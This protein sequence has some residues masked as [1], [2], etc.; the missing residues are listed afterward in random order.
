MSTW[1]KLRTRSDR[2]AR[3]R[4][5]RDER[6]ATLVLVALF[7][8]ILILMVSFVLDV[9]NWFEHKRHLQMQ[10]D[11]AALAAALDLRSPCDDAVVAS[12]AG[13]YG[14][15]D[16]NAQVQDRQADVHM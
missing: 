5:V 11:S 12:T 13:S 8:P 9:G 15:G 6:G 16:Y 3:L 7:F 14:G 4:L 1:R 10:A 2:G